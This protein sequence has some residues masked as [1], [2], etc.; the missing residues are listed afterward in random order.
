MK[1]KEF[2]RLISK[3]LGKKITKSSK[4]ELDS[5]NILQIVEFNNVNF[6]GFNINF[7]KLLI[8]STSKDLLKLYKGKIVS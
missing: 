4:F 6:K 5:L 3:S 7:Q 2:L 1:E 8:C